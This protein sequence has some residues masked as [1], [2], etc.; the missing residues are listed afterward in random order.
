MNENMN[1]AYSKNLDLTIQYKDISIPTKRNQ[2]LE[3]TALLCKYQKCAPSLV[4]VSKQPYI[5]IEIIFIGLN[6][7]VSSDIQSFRLTQNPDGHISRIMIEFSSSDKMFRSKKGWGIEAGKEYGESETDDAKCDHLPDN[8]S[9]LHSNSPY[10]LD[11]L[12][13]DIPYL[14]GYNKTLSDKH[15]RVKKVDI[16]NI[17]YGHLLYTYTKDIQKALYFNVIPLR[18]GSESEGNYSQCKLIA[19]HHIRLLVDGFCKE[20]FKEIK[21]QINRDVIQTIYENTLDFEPDLP[22]ASI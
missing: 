6:L 12:Y 11:F 18:D 7:P 4:I 22:E 14:T 21:A 2:A 8:K 13:T 1:I 15:N 17:L 19:F 10:F 16:C 3:G 20:V 5:A 9:I